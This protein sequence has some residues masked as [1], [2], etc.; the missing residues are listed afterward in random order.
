MCAWQ[1]RSAGEASGVSL[2]RTTHTPVGA[3]TKAGECEG[4]EHYLTACVLDSPVEQW[5]LRYE[6]RAA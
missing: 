1:A 5:T 6:G 4:L 3:M 2:P